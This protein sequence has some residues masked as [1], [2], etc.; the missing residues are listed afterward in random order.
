MAEEKILD[1]QQQN[2]QQRGFLWRKIAL[3]GFILLF[4][5]SG[6]F[7][8]RDLYQNVREA[9]ANQALAEQVKQA[10]E[11]K[12]TPFLQ[13]VAQSLQGKMEENPL[14]PYVWL[15]QKNPDFMGWLS[16][17]DTTLDYPVMYTPKDPEYYLHR[18]FDK[19]YA[20]SG[21]L[22]LGQGS[23]PG[24]NHLIIYGHNMRNG[25]MF[26]ALMPYAREDYWR[27]HPVISFATLTEEGEYEVVGAFYSRVYGDGE[28]DKNA[29]R[30]YRYTDLSEQAVFEEYVRR[31]KDAALYDTG[32]EAYF[33]DSLITL[34]TCS[35]HTEDGR[36]VVVARKL[37]EE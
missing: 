24:N 3:W 22:F 23:A 21:S 7:L 13:I 33:G 35:Y 11:M 12:L 28:E 9:A 18:G 4:L 30:Y 1:N 25:A 36:F 14:L 37:T 5:V 32:V 17:E 16:V 10:R 27:S 2:K 19:K 6:C 8:G 26:G 15:A 20:A 31:V 34:S 29:F